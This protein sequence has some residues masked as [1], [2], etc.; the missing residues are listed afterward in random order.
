MNSWR[1][2]WRV[3]CGRAA[4]GGLGGGTATG[5]LSPRRKRSAAF[6]GLGLSPLLA[7]DRPAGVGSLAI[8]STGPRGLAARPRRVGKKG[9]PG[10][11][12]SPVVVS[13][14]V[15]AGLSVPHQV[16]HAR[17]IG[18]FRRGSRLRP[19]GNRRSFAESLEKTLRFRNARTRTPRRQVTLSNR[20]PR[21][22]PVPLR[23]AAPV[24]MPRPRNHG[25]SDRPGLAS[26]RASRVVGWSCRG[27]HTG[28]ANDP[29]Q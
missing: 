9:S 20:G 3:W 13:P 15:A 12:A 29:I 26:G 27:T 24:R 2:S 10:W 18:R 22:R 19:G 17:A 6:P 21:R 8:A 11:P 1:S 5:G 14:V 4:V 7:A 16:S 28:T 23:R 25:S